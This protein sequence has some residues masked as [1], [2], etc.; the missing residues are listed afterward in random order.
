MTRVIRLIRLIRIVKLYKSANQAM[1]IQDEKM[2]E[3]KLDGFNLS[4]SARET[5]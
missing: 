5:T 2:S 4:K 1:A 3:K